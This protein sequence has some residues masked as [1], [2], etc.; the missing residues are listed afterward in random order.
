MSRYRGIRYFAYVLEILVLFMVQET[1]G[2]LPAVFRERAVLL[3]AAG[4]SIGS[5]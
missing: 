2:L 4:L 1:P 3:V 5:L